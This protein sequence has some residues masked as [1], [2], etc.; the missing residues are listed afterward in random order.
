MDTAKEEIIQSLSNG[1]HYIIYDWHGKC[2]WAFIENIYLVDPRFEVQ[3][4]NE[5]EELEAS[6]GC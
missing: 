5:N 4:V 2:K 1:R 6:A 3:F